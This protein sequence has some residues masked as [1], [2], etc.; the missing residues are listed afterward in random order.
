MKKYIVIDTWNGDGYSSE[1]G[2]DTKQ[3]DYR[4]SALKWA[5]KRCV[6][7]NQGD[8]DTIQRYSDQKN[9]NGEPLEWF[10]KDGNETNGDGYFWETYDDNCGSYQVWETK[11][12]YAFKILCN[13]NDVTPL[14]Y[15]E[16][17]EEIEDKE[18]L[19]KDAIAY[20]NWDETEEDFISEE[21]N[22]DVYYGSL[23]D[24]DYQFRLMKNY[25]RDS[26]F[27]FAFAEEMVADKFEKEIEEIERIEKDNN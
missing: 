5:Y 3:F 6:E 8:T 24:Y 17:L 16:Y 1:N 19:M 14:T 18:H 11:N 12:V 21:E 26:E 27:S 10:K 4:K 25:N 2:V 9:Y 22:G 20:S 13:V 7:Q 15:Q 23:D